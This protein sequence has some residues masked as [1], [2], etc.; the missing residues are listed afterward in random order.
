MVAFV[1]FVG[2]KDAHLPPVQRT[3][4]EP[5]LFADLGRTER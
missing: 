2:L 4:V 5:S 1:R 3:E